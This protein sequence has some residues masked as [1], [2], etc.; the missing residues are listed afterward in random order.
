VVGNRRVQGD[1]PRGDR[2]DGSGHVGGDTTKHADAEACLFVSAAPG[3]SVVVATFS[4]DYLFFEDIAVQQ[5]YNKTF[6]LALD[7]IPCYNVPD[8]K[9]N[10]VLKHI[11]KTQEK[12]V[13]DIDTFFFS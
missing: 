10:F 12:K 13:R 7:R 3:G 5:Y 6:L 8:I 9:T 1:D 2:R 4:C 11:N